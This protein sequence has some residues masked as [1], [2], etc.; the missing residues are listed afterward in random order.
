MAQY[1]KTIKVNNL[2]H[3]KDFEIPV[4]NEHSPNLLITGKNGSGKTILLKAVDNFL[5]KVK[6]DQALGFLSYSKYAN[7]W[8]T[9]WEKASTQ[10]EKS[11][12]KVN[13]DKWVKKS[14]D[15]FGHIDLEFQDV[16]AMVEKHSRG[17]FIFAFFDAHRK[18][19]L[20]VPKNPMKPVINPKA[21]TNVTSTSQ[22]LYFL[23]DLKIQESLA[24]NEGE[25]EDAD[26]IRDWFT[27]FENIL[28]QIF[29]DKNLKLK[30]NYRDYSFLIQNE[31]K[32]FHFTEM[33]DGY[34][35]LIDIVAD[36][37]MKMQTEGG[38]TRTYEKE[39]I[40]LIDEIENHLHLELQK[41]VMPLLT[42]LF[43]NIQF[44]VT[45]HSPFVL[46]SMKNAMA[47]D[48]EHREPVIELTQYS[49]ES[50]A[51][52]YFGVTNESGYIQDQLSLMEEL[53]K[54]DNLM[55]SQKNDLK[56]MITDFEKIPSAV[57]PT[58]V[59]QYRKLR[60][61]YFERIKELGI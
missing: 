30:F 53:L 54:N 17:E 15:M 45:T 35:A 37:I 36:L 5:N 31:E 49:Y 16:A 38:V 32:E 25:T 58:V 44:I 41:N 1:I 51:E 56:C 22:L 34:T 14:D 39:G 40:V 2:Y 8:R 11:V 23:S 42:A 55:D 43:P 61:D 27:S 47:Y 3:L 59:G 29:Q 46:S 13:M 28:K 20:K 7:F 6:G 60:N 18:C 9:Q 48:L 50:L 57:A 4:G 10:E 26:R 21:D 19:D 12:A 52:G 24:R 33:S